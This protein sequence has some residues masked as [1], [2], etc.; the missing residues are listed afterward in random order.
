MAGALTKAMEVDI[1]TCDHGRHPCHIRD[2]RAQEESKWPETAF[3]LKSE[4][5]PWCVAM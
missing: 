4:L 3:C 1:G 5:L 2:G